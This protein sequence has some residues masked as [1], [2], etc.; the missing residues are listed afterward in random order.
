MMPPDN[1]V[2]RCLLLVAFFTV[3]CAGYSQAASP[4]VSNVT[5]SQRSGTKLV[6]ICY[7]VQDSDTTSL[8]ITV[9]VS[10]NGGS[11]YAFAARTL[12]GA[13]GKGVVPGR[14]NRIVWDAGA[15]WN[16]NF[17]ANV[18]FRITADDRPIA[19]DL[20]GEMS[21]GG[22][23]TLDNLLDKAHNFLGFTAAYVSANPVPSGAYADIPVNSGV[24]IFPFRFSSLWPSPVEPAVVFT[25]SKTTWE[26]V[27]TITS[28]AVLTQ[29]ASEL[30]VSGSGSVRAI[31]PGAPNTEVP[32]TWS[33]TIDNAIP[34]I[35]W[36]VFNFSFVAK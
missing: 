33:L 35:F 7:D 14:K 5:A 15:D 17:S 34:L 23:V 1:Q 19:S 21:F 29:S 16:G 10:T 11:S 36:Q 18:R 4:T 2:T 26:Y 3:L 20:T 31:G 27:F 22:T 25:D 24:T 13:V 8:T 9:T 12:T 28:A 32:A 30:H 6:D